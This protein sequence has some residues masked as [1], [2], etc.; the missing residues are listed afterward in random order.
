M[1]VAAAV[2]LLALLPTAISAQTATGVTIIPP[3]APTPPT[4]P[5]PP[6]PPHITAGSG[7]SASGIRVEAFG[8][9]GNS[10]TVEIGSGGSGDAAG[11][12]VSNGNVVIE[13]ER[14]P[15]EVT[16]FRA[17]SGRGY[18]IDRNGGNVSVQSD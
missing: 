3:T 6:E 11:V 2:L 13:G 4:A 1:K 18:R 5:V 7:V 9:G 15:P 10:A 8:G 12:T 16:H 14:V 17:R